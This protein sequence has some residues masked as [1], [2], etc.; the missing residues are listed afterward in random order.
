MIARKIARPKP[1][2]PPEP[3]DGVFYP[4]AHDVLPVESMLHF[5][6][7]AYM[8]TALQARYADDPN[9][10]V[11]SQMFIYYQSGDAQASVAPDVCI[12]PGVA[13]APQRRS[14][15]MWLERQVPVFCME[16]VSPSTYN[17][18]TGF[19]RELYQSWGV[20]EY[21]LYDPNHD[22]PLL[23]PPLQGYRL[24]NGR[25]EPIP[26]AYDRQVDAYRGDSAVL[27][28]ELRGNREWFRFFDSSNGE[29]ILDL[30]E[31]E[32]A[33]LAERDARLAERDA[34]LAERDARLAAEA[35]IRSLEA[36]IRRLRGE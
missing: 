36:E 31:S 35:R 24:V 11:A 33:R 9:I 7:Q 4:D 34:R 8:Q 26:V 14:Y 16:V 19:K 23:T 1:S 18:D 28:W 22:Q 29:Y 30:E 10:L 5:S 6:P 15:F 13:S 17:N 12:I 21:W 2:R 20:L 3:D 25:Y 32:Q 27:D